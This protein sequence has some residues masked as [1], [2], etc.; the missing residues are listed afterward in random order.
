MRIRLFQVDPDKPDLR[1]IEIR[2]PEQPGR[3]AAL[4]GQLNDIEKEICTC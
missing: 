4:L 3:L 2:W 1:R